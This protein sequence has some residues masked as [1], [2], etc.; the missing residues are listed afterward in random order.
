MT[1]LTACRT[2]LTSTIPGGDPFTGKVNG[3]GIGPA[4][5]QD[6]KL[7][8]NLLSLGSLDHQLTHPGMTKHRAVFNLDC[9]PLSQAYRHQRCLRSITDRGDINGEAVVRLKPVSGG[10]STAQPYL[11]LH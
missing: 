1:R 6:L 5:L 11:F 9:R 10:S 7:V 3:P 2:S 8:R 4:A